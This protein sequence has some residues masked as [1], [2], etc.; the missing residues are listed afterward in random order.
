LV[1]NNTSSI[2]TLTTAVNDNKSAAE[3]VATGL[4]N[5]ITALETNSATS[6]ALNAVN[7][8]V[9]QNTEAITTLDGR[10]TQVDEQ[11]SAAID[12]V[13]KRVDLLNNTVTTQGNTLSNK[14]DSST[15]TAL[16][17][18]VDNNKSAV[19]TALAAKAE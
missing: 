11:A 16:E 15:V 9:G 4:S 17:T 12:A 1:S 7:A 2:S 3:S 8:V 13:D 5:R 19:D 10:I 14:A 6:E 18:K